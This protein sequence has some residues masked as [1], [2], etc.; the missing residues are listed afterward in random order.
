MKSVCRFARVIV[1]CGTRPIY[2]AWVSKLITGN[3]ITESHNYIYIYKIYT[4][5]IYIWVCVGARVRLSH[6]FQ[7]AGQIETRIIEVVTDVSG[8]KNFTA[9]VRTIVYMTCIILYNK[10]IYICVYY[11]MHVLCSGSRIKTYELSIVDFSEGVVRHFFARRNLRVLTTDRNVW[12]I[13]KCC[14][15]FCRK[16][17]RSGPVGHAFAVGREKKCNFESYYWITSVLANWVTLK[18]G[19]LISRTFCSIN[20]KSPEVNSSM[21]PFF[22]FLDQYALV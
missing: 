11:D 22:F 12:Y 19:Y 8:G 4:Y 3:Y 14:D 6:E 10:Y 13:N 1:F 18:L 7:S 21:S 20:K 5:Y 9:H 16:N 2:S 15:R 17:G